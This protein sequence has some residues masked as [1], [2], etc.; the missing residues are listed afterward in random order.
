M[1][2]YYVTLTFHYTKKEKNM[3][4]FE[5]PLNTRL[6][7]KFASAIYYLSITL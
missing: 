1:K 2:L 4:N 3:K 7:L 6:S 5:A